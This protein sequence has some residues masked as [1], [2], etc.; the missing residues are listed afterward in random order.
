MHCVN[1]FT[2][3]ACAPSS[4]T[5]LQH[6]LMD[7]TLPPP[8]MLLLQVTMLQTFEKGL[9]VSVSFCLSHRLLL[10]TRTVSGPMWGPVWDLSVMAALK[11]A[12]EAVGSAP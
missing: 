1:E 7:Q 3:Q 8:M 5:M 2:C 10:T 4:K 12:H 11:Q 6:S 9:G